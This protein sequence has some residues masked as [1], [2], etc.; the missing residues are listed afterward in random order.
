MSLEEIVVEKG[1][2]VATITLN[3]PDRLN[4][5]TQKMI[6]EDLPRIW[7]DLEHDKK[8]RCIIFTGSGERAFCSGMD[9]KEAAAS[10]TWGK[11][12]A[13]PR[14]SLMTPRQAA[15]TKPV[16]AAVNGICVGGGQM[17]VSDCDIAIASTNATFSNPG[18]SIGQLAVY[19]PITWSKYVSFQS[20]MR[21]MLVGG[22]ERLSAQQAKD[23][24]I[25]TEVVPAAQLMTRSREVA[26]MI[27]A[28]SPT[29]VRQ[30]KKIM[31]DCLDRN[32]TDAF[33]NGQAIMRAY[34]GHPDSI[35]GPKAF[36]E[37]RKPKWSEE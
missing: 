18:V 9:L 17:F 5:V 3:R 27:A 11:A 31:W 32:L 2:G 8:V 16:I 23:L 24:G 28:N 37:K 19:A 10:P 14:K 20:L 33:A 25:V 15:V 21:M 7:S 6:N 36:A 4:S 1:E 26:A 35:E 13:Q 30:V 12:P 29:A 34:M 22:A